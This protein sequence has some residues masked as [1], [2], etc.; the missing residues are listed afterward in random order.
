MRDNRA[1]IAEIL[2]NI[3]K[4]DGSSYSRADLEMT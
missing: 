1:L 3:M 4:K 2:F